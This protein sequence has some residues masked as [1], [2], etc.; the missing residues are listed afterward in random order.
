MN[1]VMKLKYAG[2]KFHYFVVGAE[3]IAN[4][5]LRREFIEVENRQI[6][7]E[8]SS[9][10][11]LK[12]R[13]CA[14]E[15]KVVPKTIMSNEMFFDSVN[16]AANLGYDKFD[17][18]PC[19]GDIFID[20]HILEK[21]HFLDNHPKVSQFGFFT[22]LVI[23]SHDQLIQL[24]G[25]KKLSGMTVSIYGHDEKSFIGITKSNL[26]AYNRLISNLKMMLTHKTPSFPLSFGWRSTGDV[27]KKDSS[28]LMELLGKFK[29]AGVYVNFPHGI[30]NNWGGLVSQDDVADL[31]MKIISGD[32]KYKFGACIKLF[33]SIQITASGVVNACSCRDVNSTLRIGDIK[34]TPLSN[35]ISSENK[36]YMRII[37]EQQ[38][39]K[40]MSICNDCDFYRSI[41]H[42][43]SYYRRDKI[44]AQT[45][46]QFISNLKN[47]RS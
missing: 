19:T 35:I 17:L 2:N 27:P 4:R 37:K 12:C 21:L 7:I 46:S 28:E 5:L 34:T 20:K 6:S 39:G 8:I 10:C 38:A 32:M 43:P 1:L 23:P 42:K 30:F 9:I 36:D 14:Y 22:N 11:N 33:G 16:Q 25:F 41:Y 44:P 31:N 24:M 13:F 3:I 26:T 29:K 15:K 45:L 47:N 18:T 40:F